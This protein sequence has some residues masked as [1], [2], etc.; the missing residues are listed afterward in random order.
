MKNKLIIATTNQGKVK[1]FAHYLNED[2][3]L[4][5]LKDINFTDEIIE[6]GSTF[7][8]NA[9]IK[10]RA[11]YHQIKLPVLADDSGLEVEVLAGAPGVYSARYAGTGATDSANMDLL[12]SNLRDH[13]NRSARFFCALVYID[14]NGNEFV[15]EGEIKGSIRAN[16]IG[17]NGFGYDPLFVPQNHE[18]SFAEMSLEEKKSMSHRGE[19]LKKFVDYLHPKV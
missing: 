10:A 18:R 14:L 16:K 4:L 5:T 6:D 7:H 19:A 15:F 1:E 3:N 13:S 8:E 2:F 12:L 9:L 17:S 11:I